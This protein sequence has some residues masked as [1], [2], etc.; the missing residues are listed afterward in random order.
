SFL[1]I[2]ASFVL[3]SSSCRKNKPVNPIDQLPPE[4]QTGANTFGCLVDGEVF[5]PGGA[6][7]S[8]GSLGCNYQFLGNGINGG[9]YFRLAAVYQN[10]TNG[11]GKSIGI[12]T[13]GLAIKENDKLLLTI[14]LTKGKAS[15][16]YSNYQTQPTMNYDGYSTTSIISGELWLKKLDTINQI[17][18]GTFWFDAVNANGQK[19]QI[20]E[21][22][23]D[24][25]YTR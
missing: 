13:D 9:Y 4:T 16:G 5:K 14:P 11:S 24:V 17:V 3:L 23:F 10:N 8:G 20:R 1:I 18:S 25:R 12:N 7:L 15:A 21:G 22:R 6:Q 2:A 19:V